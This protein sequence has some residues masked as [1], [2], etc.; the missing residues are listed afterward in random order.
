MDLVESL[1]EEYW[2]AVNPPKGDRIVQN[3]A[4]V[5]KLWREIPMLDRE[6]ARES[7]QLSL[8]VVGVMRLLGP[9][10]WDHLVIEIDL[11]CRD[12]GH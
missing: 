6:E 7:D 1:Q 12:G 10:I 5:D 8:V 3:R 9:L 2:I 11:Y 4:V